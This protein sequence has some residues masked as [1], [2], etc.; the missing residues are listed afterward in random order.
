MQ[1]SLSEGHQ[2][3]HRG[4]FLADCGVEPYVASPHNGASDLRTGASE[5][6]GSYDSLFLRCRR[7]GVP[8]QTIPS[9]L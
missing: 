2:D 1:R 4:H 7:A 6:I 8:L 5:H 3:S 9:H